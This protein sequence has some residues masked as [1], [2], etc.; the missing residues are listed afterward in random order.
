MNVMIMKMPSVVY[1]TLVEPESELN[2]L[3]LL[4]H[5]FWKALCLL[6]PEC[7]ISLKSVAHRTATRPE[8]FGPKAAFLSLFVEEF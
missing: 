4:K 6:S 2:V 3:I 1:G 7:C 8:K 5:F